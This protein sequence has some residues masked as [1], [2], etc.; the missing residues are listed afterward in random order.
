MSRQLV[1]LREYARSREARNLPGG[2]LRAVQKAIASGRISTVADEKGRQK[3]DSEVA[4]IQW[5]SNTDPEQS[6][7]ANPGRDIGLPA[8]SAAQTSA[9]AP[10]SEDG[11]KSSAY[12]EARTR[13][14]QAEAEQSE[15]KLRE[16]AGELVQRAAVKRA[17]YEAGRLLRDMVLAIPGA[18]APELAHLTE[19]REVEIRLIDELRKVLDQV[20]RVTETSL[21]RRIDA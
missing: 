10:A 7:R 12:W 1:S 2:S 4:D 20:A 3:I 16:M 13:R 5:N 9:P 21:D 14:E 6:M 17:S 11:P 8:A 18:I 19:A 15:I